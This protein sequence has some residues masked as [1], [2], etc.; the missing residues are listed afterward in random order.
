MRN[1]QP[2]QDLTDIRV[3]FLQCSLKQLGS[4][5]VVELS[6]LAFGGRENRR[7]RKAAIHLPKRVELRLLTWMPPQY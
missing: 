2:Y 4:Y 3:I 7:S 6:G 5:A 1:L